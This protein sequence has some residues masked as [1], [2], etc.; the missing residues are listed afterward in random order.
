MWWKHVRIPSVRTNTDSLRVYISSD[1]SLLPSLQLIWCYCCCNDAFMYRFIG[2]ARILPGVKCFP[3]ARSAVPR[4]LAE[5]HEGS[6]FATCLF[7]IRSSVI[8]KP[9]LQTEIGEA[10]FGWRILRSKKW[11]LMVWLI[12]SDGQKWTTKLRTNISTRFCYTQF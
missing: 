1:C 2:C 9:T 11:E 8:G 10:L 6:Q 12:I 4:D 7:S 5:Y 3:P